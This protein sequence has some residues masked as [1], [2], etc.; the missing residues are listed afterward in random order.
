MVRLGDKNKNIF[1][2]ICP[3]NTPTPN[4][5][6]LTMLNNGIYPAKSSKPK[7]KGTVNDNKNSV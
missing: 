3:K 6:T 5:N 4:P 2:I 7:I 1:K